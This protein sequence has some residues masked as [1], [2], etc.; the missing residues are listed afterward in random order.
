ME[1]KDTDLAELRRAVLND[2]R[3]GELR[4]L[5]GV[6]MAQQRDY[7]G[8]VLEL[9]AAIALS[10]YLHVARFQLGLLHLT[11]AQPQHCVAVLAPLESLEDDAPLKLFK[12]GLEALIKDD[13]ADCLQQLRRG[14]ELNTQNEPLNRDMALLIER[15]TTVL[16]EQE[17]AAQTA[18]QDGDGVRT[19][20][21]LYGVTKH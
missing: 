15:V 11:L 20:F 6:E 13:F 10:P 16:R 5:L 7:D 12:R 14:I 1:A 21:S 18:E 19:D 3:N 2:P 8:A 9:S 4:Y 17:S